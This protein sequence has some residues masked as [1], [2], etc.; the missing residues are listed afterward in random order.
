M[1]PI[2]VPALDFLYVLGRP[3]R[4]SEKRNRS[5]D[6]ADDKTERRDENS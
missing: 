1:L 6:R 2:L 3:S 5:R 4:E